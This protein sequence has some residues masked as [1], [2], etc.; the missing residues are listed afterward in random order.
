MYNGFDPYGLQQGQYTPIDK[1]HEST[2][3]NAAVSDN[4]MDT[5][6]GGVLYTEKVVDSGKYKHREVEP[7]KRI[8]LP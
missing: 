7:P 5:N 4:P 6:W 1:I 2:Q 8:Y 3:Q